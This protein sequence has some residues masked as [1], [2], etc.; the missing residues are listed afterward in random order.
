MQEAR[1]IAWDAWN[2]A[3]AA[4]APAAVEAAAGAFA[5]AVLTCHV[6]THSIRVAFYGAAAVAFDRVGVNETREVY[7]AI[8]ADECARFEAALRAIA[9]ENEPNP[10]PCKWSDMTN[11]PKM[12]DIIANGKDGTT[13]NIA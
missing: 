1:G 8:A 2:I 5:N 6:A 7:D 13:E 4:K 9:V 10:A 3:R 12:P 11:I